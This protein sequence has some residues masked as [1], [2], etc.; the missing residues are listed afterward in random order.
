M[1]SNPFNAALMAAK[2]HFNASWVVGAAPRTPVHWPNQEP[3]LPPATG[4]WAR[5]S[6]TFGE[7]RRVALGGR[8]DRWV[9]QVVVQIFAPIGTGDGAAWQ[10]SDAVF[11]IFGADRSL[12]TGDGR[13]R[14]WTPTARPVP[15]NSGWFQINVICPFQRDRT[16]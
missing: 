5:F 9:G 13:L 2:A 11:D 4:A 15:G 1:S 3:F 10:L 14:F 12:F 8:M 6:M 7:G 16:L